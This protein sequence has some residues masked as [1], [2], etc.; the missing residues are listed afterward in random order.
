MFTAHALAAVGFGALL[1]FLFFRLDEVDSDDLRSRSSAIF[2]SM[3]V[4]SLAGLA[5]ALGLTTERALAIRE[6]RTKHYRIFTYVSVHS[7]LSFLILRFIPICLFSAIFLPMS[8]LQTWSWS[9]WARSMRIVLFVGGLTAFWGTFAALVS[10]ALSCTVKRG[11]KIAAVVL[12]TLYGPLVSGFL[13]PKDELPTPARYLH[14]LSPFSVTFEALMISEFSRV[15]F[16]EVTDALTDEPTRDDSF[17]AMGLDES[18]LV[19]DTRISVGFYAG[20]LVIAFIGVWARSRRT[21]SALWRW[22]K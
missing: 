16:N 4:L 8:E 22:F 6:I 14:Y 3:V 21:N 18:N 9:T 7:V 5:S 17:H 12:I 10:F 19:I 1:G 15:G 11:L 2:L 13:I 20:I